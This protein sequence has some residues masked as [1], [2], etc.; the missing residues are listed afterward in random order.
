MHGQQNVKILNYVAALTFSCATC[1]IASSF[2]DLL[3][4]SRKSSHL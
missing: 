2:A 3:P 1:L 4:W